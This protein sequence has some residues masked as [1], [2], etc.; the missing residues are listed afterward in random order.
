MDNLQEIRAYATTL[1]LVHKKN[2]SEK[3]IHETERKEVS[4]T[5]F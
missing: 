5:E 4:Y 1:S 2:E 3:L